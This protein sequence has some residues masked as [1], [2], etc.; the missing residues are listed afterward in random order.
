MPPLLYLLTVGNLVVGSSAF[1]I[2]GLVAEIAAGLGVSVGVA[3]LAMTAYALAVA[4]CAPLLVVWTG[5]WPRRRA[6]LLAL[7]LFTAGN[8]LCALAG[9]I[10]PFYAGRVL[11]GLGSVFTPL[12]AGLA[13]A[14]VAPERRGQALSTVFLGM[15]LS[16]VIGL[17]LGTFI[18]LREGWQAAVS[19]TD[20]LKLAYAD[21]L[22]HTA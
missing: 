8:A 17:P 15:S 5:R 21:F 3:G 13:I 10:A 9:S 14:L 20:G 12:S 1:V 19:L 6:L 18:G 22:S 11:M 16:Y 4:L 2:S 7:A